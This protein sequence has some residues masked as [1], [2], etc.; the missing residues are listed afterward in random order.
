MLHNIAE[1][2]LQNAFLGWDGRQI[3]KSQYGI[4]S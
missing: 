2:N 3:G 1:K 4:N